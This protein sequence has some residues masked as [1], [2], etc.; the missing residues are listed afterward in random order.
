MTHPST[1]PPVPIQCPKCGAY[2]IAGASPTIEIDRTTAFC[3]NCSH[4]WRVRA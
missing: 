4:A 1:V 3:N 2:D